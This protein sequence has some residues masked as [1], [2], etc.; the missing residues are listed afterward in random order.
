MLSNIYGYI[1]GAEDSNDSFTSS[2]NSSPIGEPSV[3]GKVDDDWYLVE[4][5]VP[6]GR[7]SAVLICTPDIRDIDQL[8]Y[9][10]S[11]RKASAVAPVPSPEEI[12][13]HEELKR[14][15]A[16]AA[17]RLQLEKLFFD[18][19]SST[20]GSL[21]RGA[22]TTH[23]S[24]N[25]NNTVT[26]TRLK[27]SSAACRVAAEPKVKPRSKKAGKCCNGVNNNRKCNN[28]E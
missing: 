19:N 4:G 11:S 3:A 26:S 8:S 25:S 15:K 27:R 1:F 7:N 21:V 20:N 23:A 18:D 16:K 28:I 13:K 12:R 14:A 6:S 2:E 5:E 17:Q 10:S 22:T 9:A 24:V